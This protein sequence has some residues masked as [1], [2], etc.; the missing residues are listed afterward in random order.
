MAREKVAESGK[1]E[2]RRKKEEGRRKKEEEKKKQNLLSSLFSLLPFYLY[3]DG[4]FFC[5]HMRR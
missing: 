3:V 1:K 4:S 5:W 2:G